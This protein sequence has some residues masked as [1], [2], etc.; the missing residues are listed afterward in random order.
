MASI[1]SKVSALIASGKVKVSLHAVQELVNDGLFI[2]PLID[3]I[4]KCQVVEE[5]P[6]YHKGPCVLVLQFDSAHKPIHLLWGIPSGK[7]EPAVLVTAYRPDPDRWDK[8]F[9]R[10]LPK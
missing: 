1:V 6:D 8:T 5:Y 9:T 2:E 4:D 7:Q 10:R 3:D